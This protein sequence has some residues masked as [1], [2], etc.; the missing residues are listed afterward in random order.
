MNP[1]TVNSESDEILQ[2]LLTHPEAEVDP[3]WAKEQTE[4]YPAFFMPAALLLK[5]NPAKVD[6]DTTQ[7]LRKSITISCPDRVAL[8]DFIDPGHA[9]WDKFYPLPQIVQANTEKTIDD[10][11]TTYGKSS[12]PAEDALLEKILFNPAPVDYFSIASDD[13]DPEDPLAL[14]PELMSE[15]MRNATAIKAEAKTEQA[16]PAPE[17]KNKPQHHSN[18]H[19]GGEDTLLRESLAKIFIKQHRYERAFEI[20][21]KLSLNYPE[22]SIYFADQL[23]FLQKLIINQQCLDK[24]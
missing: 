19:I 16:A 5:R 14:P 8:T 9:G 3:A 1:T 6:A 4:K 7:R 22:K 17:L 12:T 15:E 24:E 2:H 23:R 11:I 21:S 20:I 10:F 18:S 13:Y